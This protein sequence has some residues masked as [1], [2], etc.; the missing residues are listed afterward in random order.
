MN[1]NEILVSIVVPVYNTSKYLDECLA[2]LVNQTL[3]EIEIICVND[4]STDNSLEVLNSW[5]LKDS[6]IKVID[7]KE[8]I[9][10]GG[11][12]NVG[13]RKARG[14]YIGLVDS[15]DYISDDM[16][17]MLVL[18]SK[19]Y[20]VDIVVSNLWA[21]HS[22]SDTFRT[23]F[24]E[25]L[26]DIDSIKKSVLVNG[27]HMVTNIIKKSLFEDYDLWYP[28]NL[29]FEDNAN[30]APLFLMAKDIE[31]VQNTAPF[32]YYRIN[33][34]STTRSKNNTRCWDRLITANIFYNHIKRLGKYEKYKQEVDYSYY[35][36]YVVN[37][38]RYALFAFSSYQ[39]NQVKEIIN[40]Y[41]KFCENNKVKTNKYYLQNKYS[42]Q[43]I[44]TDIICCLPI[45][46]YL[47]WGYSYFKQLLKNIIKIK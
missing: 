12:R 32:Y 31:L 7:L 35:R 30:T 33:N 23:N 6:R 21:T 11:A 20:T 44:L 39:Y 15:D 22:D 3:K 13:I 26:S 42:F 25:G 16:Y 29:S 27:C 4:A 43:G 34:Q 45:S 28:E 14:L 24:R 5:A 47:V 41:E 46:G 2:S 9:R 38:L 40:E 8:N 10:Q 1:N 18:N 37:S 17:E 19:D 36:M